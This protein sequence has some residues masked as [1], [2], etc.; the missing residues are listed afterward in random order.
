[1]TDPEIA[2]KTY[3][4]PLTPEIVSNIILKEK[5]DAIPEGHTATFILSIDSLN[6]FL[7]SA[8]LIAF[9]SA[10]INSILFSFKKPFS[11]KLT[12]KI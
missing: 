10:P 2:N 7:S 6:N 3:I 8:F 11:D 1:M 12:A 5:P 9:K 4:E